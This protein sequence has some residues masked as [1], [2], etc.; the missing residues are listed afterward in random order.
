MVERK[1]A[2]K[3]Q[4]SLEWCKYK[5]TGHLLETFL[6]PLSWNWNLAPYAM[7]KCPRIVLLYLIICLTSGYEHTLQ[8]MSW[9]DN[10]ETNVYRY[11]S[12]S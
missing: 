4:K 3:A 2:P 5:K 6:T 7:V 10:K 12:K 1:V 8:D 11:S 9:N